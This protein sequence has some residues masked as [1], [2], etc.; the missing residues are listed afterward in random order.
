MLKITDFKKNVE[1][2]VQALGIWNS[3]NFFSAIKF[4]ND[5]GVGSSLVFLANDKNPYSSINFFS[6]NEVST[7]PTET[8]VAGKVTL[9]VLYSNSF[10]N[11]II[12]SVRDRRFRQAIINIFNMEKESKIILPTT[13]PQNTQDTSKNLYGQTS[14]L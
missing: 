3:N 8:A 13:T 12:Y 9:F 11:F 6:L 1:F 14:E 7:A 4:F 2:F 5:L 10:W